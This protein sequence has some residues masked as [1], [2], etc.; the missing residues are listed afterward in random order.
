MAVIPPSSDCGAADPQV[1]S[2]AMRLTHFYADN[3]SAA[4][5]GQTVDFSFVL[6]NNGL[7]TLFDVSMRSD[8][9]AE[10]GSKVTCTDAGGNTIAGAA[11]GSIGGMAPY[12]DNGMAPGQS[13]S[14]HSSVSVLQAE[15]M[16]N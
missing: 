4:V 10:R 2:M 13:I 12:P 15:V 1:G 14:C 3:T 9:L 7:L 8:Y 6:S 5:V 11:A 16:P